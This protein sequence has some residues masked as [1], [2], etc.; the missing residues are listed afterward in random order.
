MTVVIFFVLSILLG[1]TVDFIVEKTW[2]NE[3][4]EIIESVEEAVNSGDYARALSQAEI[5]DWRNDPE[6]NA[7]AEKARE[8][9]TVDLERKRQ[10]RI[11]NLIIEIGDSKDDVREEKLEE[12]LR[13]DPGTEAYPE[14]ITKIREIIEQRREMIIQRE[15]EAKAKREAEHQEKIKR[16]KE[17]QEERARL[18]KEARL[19]KFK[20]KYRAVEDKLTSKTIYLAWVRSLNQVNFDFP[21]R[22]LQRGELGLE[23]HP[24]HGKNLFLRVEKGQMLV[25]SYE[26]RIIRVVFDKDDPISYSVVGPSDYGTTSLFFEDYHGFVGRMLKAKTVKISVP[27]YQEGNVVFE[28]NVSDFDSDN[29]LGRN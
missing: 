28:F 8:L 5:H 10:K 4:G 2:K 19:A 20:W 27:F 23:T 18:E 14:E 24:E 21:Y 25:Q 7:L 1:V 11:D 9:K 22:G 16:K 6:L 3:R 29:Y 15:T 12:L 13:L 26:S 17:A